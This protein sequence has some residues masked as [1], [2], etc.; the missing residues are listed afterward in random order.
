MLRNSEEEKNPKT[1]TNKILKKIS[2]HFKI[3]V[4]QLN[5]MPAPTKKN[6]TY[7]YFTTQINIS[8]TKDNSGSY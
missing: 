7:K 8:A 1:C 6:C 5:P 4:Q 3:I 2:M